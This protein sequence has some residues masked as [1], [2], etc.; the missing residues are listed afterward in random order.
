[1]VPEAGIEPASR[2]AEDF[3]SSVFTNFTIRAKIT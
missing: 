2:E 1:M 3:K